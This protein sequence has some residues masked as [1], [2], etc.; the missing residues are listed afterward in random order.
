MGDIYGEVEYAVPIKCDNESAIKLAENPMIMPVLERK[1][2]QQSVRSEAQV[3]DMF[4]KALVKHKFQKFREALGLSQI[5][6]NARNLAAGNNAA[7]SVVPW[8]HVNLIDRR[9]F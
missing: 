6:L 3:A 5:E 2:K 1:V 9:D 4:T 8:P 7:L